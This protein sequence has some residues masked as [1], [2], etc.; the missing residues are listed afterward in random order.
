MIRYFTL[1]ASLIAL[2]YANLHSQYVMHVHEFI[3]SPLARFVHSSSAS[4]NLMLS[5][6]FAL[7]QNNFKGLE[8]A[9]YTISTPGS[10]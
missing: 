2:V 1:L 8:D 4:A 9:L 5:L 10:P 6:C 7:V 3:N